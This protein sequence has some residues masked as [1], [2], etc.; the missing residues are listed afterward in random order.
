MSDFRFSMW[1]NIDD[2]IHLEADWVFVEDGLS[3]IE[4]IIEYDDEE[5]S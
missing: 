2:P 1:K 3:P 4:A 5:Y